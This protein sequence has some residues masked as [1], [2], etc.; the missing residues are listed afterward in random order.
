MPHGESSWLDPENSSCFVRFSF[1]LK[2]NPF[3]LIF[4]FPD[5]GLRR[6][7]LWRENLLT[8]KRERYEEWLCRAGLLM[9]LRRP[10][11]PAAPPVMIIAILFVFITI[12][13]LISLLCAC[14]IW[15]VS[16]WGSFLWPHTYPYSDIIFS[17]K[18]INISMQPSGNYF[19]HHSWWF[20]IICFTPIKK[21]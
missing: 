17:S 16:L 14:Y 11:R 13:F 2:E 1:P 8:D 18:H 12:T 5:L 4:I 20:I 6:R 15:A 21:H 10:T 19:N 9:L 7:A 3:P